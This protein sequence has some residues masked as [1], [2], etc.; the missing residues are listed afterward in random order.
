MTIETLNDEGQ[1][2]AD[3]IRLVMIGTRD[4]PGVLLEEG[5][6]RD[7]KPVDGV[8]VVYSEGVM[9][10]F[11]FHAERL[12]KARSEVTALV[13]AIVQ[14]AFLKSGGGGYTF[15]NLPFDRSDEQ[16]GE[17]ANAD[18]LFCLAQA[19]GMA[20][21]CMSREYWDILPGGMPYVW[22]DA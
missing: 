20:G 12:E 10:K 22:F 1:S 3:R 14:D 5:E 9:R 16:W 8:N 2:Y 4:R 7:G 6:V 11:G 15:L 19:L 21:M 18:D 17:H 13:K